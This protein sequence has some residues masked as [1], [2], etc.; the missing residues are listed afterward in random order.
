MRTAAISASE[1]VEQDRRIAAAM[2]QERARLKRFIARHVPDPFDVEDI[3]Q[4]VFYELVAA[5]RFMK[6]VRQAGAWLFRVAQNRIHDLFRER[7][8]VPLDEPVNDDS[9]SLADLLPSAD[10]GPETAYARSLLLRELEDAIAELPE[11]QRAVFVAHEID[12]RSFTDLAAETR[13]SINTLLARKRY[14][15]LRLRK[16]LKDIYDELE[17]E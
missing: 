11:D 6:P 14:A 7:R 1:K 17:Q 8:T 2:D 3:L 15:V 13:L 12:G 9:P 10:G 16:R 4:D 5:Y